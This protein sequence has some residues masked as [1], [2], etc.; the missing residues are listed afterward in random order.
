MFLKSTNPT[1]TTPAG[2]PSPPIGAAYPNGDTTTA[3]ETAI[4]ARRAIAIN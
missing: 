3:V 2:I 4:K 1:G